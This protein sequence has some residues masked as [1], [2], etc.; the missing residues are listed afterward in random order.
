[1]TRIPIY[2]W[3]EKDRRGPVLRKA[4]GLL[5]ETLRD[6]LQSPAVRDPGLED[7]R[8]I[9]RLMAKLGIDAVDLGLPGAGARARADV[10]ALLRTIVDERLPIAATCAARTV[11]ADITP[12]IE[13]SQRVGA[14]IEISVFIGASAIRATA[15]RW[16][17]DGLARHTRDAVAAVV[18]AG[19]P[20]AFVT[21]DTTRS[22]PA[23]LD[24]LFRTAIE[25]G[26]QRLVLC[27]TCG[28]ATPDGVRNL[29][30]FAR[31][32]LRA[33]DVEARVA[34]DW[35]GHNDRG[36]ALT[37]ALFALEWGA[38]RV[39]GCALG[40]GE[41]T[42]N[43]PMDLLLLNLHLL[44]LL[45]P[46]RHDHTVLVEY[47]ERVSAATGVPIPPSYPLAGRDAFRTATGVHAAAVAKAEQRGDVELA[48]G[49]YS[50]VPAHDFGRAQEI[51]IGHYSGRA[52]VVWWLRHHGYELDDARIS[53]MLEHAK[54]H[55][56]V[57]ADDELHALARAAQSGGRAG[58]SAD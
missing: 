37:N 36:H 17:L 55:D 14:P 21:E 8:A 35:H 13:V 10:E 9:L 28:H 26:A 53:R 27:D 1:M 24:R 58:A 6:G 29:I 31:G 30:V 20:A 3:N 11:L 48:D 57:L 46:A 51:A 22:H 40:I 45:D 38:D 5:D 33:L 41:R 15:E 50:S 4:P 54:R 12:A 34:I 32:V 39:H 56:R 19:L 25:A 7:K 23:A 47:V 49:V 2:D 52:N 43:T 18:A 42:G 44:G 16:D